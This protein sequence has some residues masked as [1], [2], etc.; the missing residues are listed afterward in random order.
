MT[1]R[2]LVSLAVAAFLAVIM[3][4][5]NPSR[6]QAG[7][8]HLVPEHALVQASAMTTT[9]TGLPAGNMIVWPEPIMGCD[10]DFTGREGRELAAQDAAVL[11]S[12]AATLMVAQ[13]DMAHSLTEASQ[14]GWLY[15]D[16]GMTLG[17]LSDMS[18][19]IVGDIARLDELV[20]SLPDT[21]EQLRG[22]QAR[23]V[24]QLCKEQGNLL[25]SYSEIWIQVATVAAWIT[26]ARIH[27]GVVVVPW[28]TN[29]FMEMDTRIIRAQVSSLNEF[30][31][32]ECLDELD[33]RL[34]G[35]IVK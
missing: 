26:R 2:M 14:G 6:A 8:G 15:I 24:Q 7:N 35:C 20:V 11:R 21:D 3:S 13:A 17:T 27:A 28:T 34:G 33:R 31:G 25:N 18:V 10:Q 30:V 16:Y 23:Q 29:R 12:L 19:R 22:R 4:I 1:K 32:P 5:I 9:P